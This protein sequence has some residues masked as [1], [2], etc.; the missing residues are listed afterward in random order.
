MYYHYSDDNDVSLLVIGILALDPG[1][2]SQR[3]K[4][5]SVFRI[6]INTIKGNEGSLF[7]IW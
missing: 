3:G 5:V 1:L 2:V 7:K 4:K 6:C